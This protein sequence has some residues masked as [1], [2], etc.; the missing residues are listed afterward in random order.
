MSVN[1]SILCG[2][3]LRR[4][5]SSELLIWLVMDKRRN[6]TLNLYLE[7]IKLLDTECSVEWIQIGES[8]TIALFRLIPT[9]E[10]AWPNGVDIEYELKDDDS[11][12]VYDLS[13]L[14]LSR[15]RPSFCYNQ[16]MSSVIQ[17]SCRKPDHIAKDAFAGIYAKLQDGTLSRPDYLIMAGDQIYADDVSAPMLIGAQLL[18]KKLK[19]YSATHYTDALPRTALEWQ[20]SVNKRHQLLPQKEGLSRWQ[21]FWHGST[22]ISARFHENHLITLDEFFATYLLTWST[23]CWQLVMDEVELAAGDFS[24]LEQKKYLEELHTVKQFIEELDRFEAVVANVPTL[25]IFD[26]HDITDDWNLTADWE[27]HIYGNTVTKHMIS[28]GLL[29]YCLFQGWGN[30]PER[31]DPII[32]KLRS[33]A[34]KKDFANKQLT[35]QLLDFNQWDYVVET[36]P[37]IAVLDTRTQRWR[38]ETSAKNPSGLMDWRSLEQLEDQ[39]YESFGSILVVSAAPVFGV[40]A[41]E[42]VQKACELV[43]QELLVDVENWMA[44]QGSARK[45]MSMMRHDNAPDEIIILSGDVH[46]SFCFSAERRFSSSTDKIWQLTCSGFKNEFPQKLLKFFDYIDRFLY[47]QYSLLNIFTKRRKLAVDH[48]PLKTQ[49]NAFKH[50]NGRHLVSSSAAGVVELDQKGMLK[51]YRLV[52]GSGDIHEFA[53]DE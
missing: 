6:L 15:T 8:A 12:H 3:I 9:Y 4:L 27:S 30:N 43:G 32:E 26:D 19:L 53:L 25:M 18:S 34:L 1:P 42:V 35:E 38:S 37:R 24:G 51:H 7:Q 29:S 52:T 16:T 31:L 46:Y 28:D 45:L 13:H 40:K 10:D 21:N 50:L 17:G 44:H 14:S 20:K 22:I 33:L 47:S 49:D 39:L 5:L 23:T 2:P 48:H 36:S 11:G 41:I